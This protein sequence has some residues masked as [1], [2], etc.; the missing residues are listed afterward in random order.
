[1]SK[2]RNEQQTAPTQPS[3]ELMDLAGLELKR[4]R[5]LRELA[6]IEARRRQL[7][8]EIELKGIPIPWMKNVSRN[9]SRG[10]P[11]LPR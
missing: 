2:N 3:T 6:E 10:V 11:P 7:S 1:M 5:L 9:S 4:R 8:R